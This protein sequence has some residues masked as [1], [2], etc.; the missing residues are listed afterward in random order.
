MSDHAATANAAPPQNL[1]SV[2]LFFVL[3]F[4]SWL[5]WIPAGARAAGALPFPWPM[6]V[7]WLGV[8]SP[9]IFGVI[10]TARAGGRARVVRFFAQFVAWRFPLAYWL[11]ALFAMPAAAL[12]A[13]CALSLMGDSGLLADGLHRLATGEAMQAVMTRDRARIY[14]SIGLFTAFQDW[15]ATSAI[16]F[17][18][19]FVGLAI[20]DGGVSE[21]PGW[22]AFAYPRLRDCPCSNVHYAQQRFKRP[23]R[24]ERLVVGQRVK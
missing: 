4:S 10:L 23:R 13:A 24:C 5:L 14:E 1:G 19:G 17:A 3:I 18:L 7:A 22:R 8:F 11:Y 20:V 16:A 9:M 12:L 21:E 6:E 15:Q 2:W